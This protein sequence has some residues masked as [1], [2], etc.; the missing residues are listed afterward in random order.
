MRTLQR[1]SM[2]ACL[3]VLLAS[4]TLHAGSS[5]GC[6]ASGIGM[7]DRAQAEKVALELR[8]LG[9]EGLAAALQYYD[10]NPDPALQ[11]LIDTVAGQRDAVHSRLYWYTDLDQALAAAQKLNRPV[12]SL[13][14][15]GKL[16]DEYSCAN[17]R[18]FRTAL[19]ANRN[20][21]AFLRDNYVPHWSSERPVP[22]VT[23]DFRDGRTLKRTITGNSIHYVLS[24]S[25]QVVDALPG[26]Y[27][28]ALFL[29]TLQQA[30][31]VARIAD[32]SSAPKLASL[33]STDP[34]LRYHL[35]YQQRQEDALLRSYEALGKAAGVVNVPA[36]NK[37]NAADAAPRAMGKA[38]VEMPMLR[39]IN[40][41]FA[42]QLADHADHADEAT[43]NALAGRIVSSLDEG[44]I[45]LIRHQLC[46]A[47]SGKKSP[48]MDEQ[49][50][51][52]VVASFERVMAR[53]TAQNQFRFRR[54]ILSW[55]IEANQQQ[56]PLD[57]TV[58]NRR[59]YDELFLTPA[60]DPWLGLVPEDTYSALTADGRL[61]R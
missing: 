7:V 17:S 6:I 35:R 16:T 8:G 45:E 61:N 60:S 48:L 12:L 36:A 14:L 29:S 56:R 59:V 32:S 19:Y 23:I 41:E 52:R 34:V 50:L 33:G 58:L 21:S 55:L 27:A 38:V 10:K 43:W 30:Q 40:P 46:T 53:D 31:Y 25:G 51:K 54:Q 57:M 18:F 47:P 20:V 15:L 39:Q 49:Q 11:P 37:P 22:V 2:A 28:P 5:P 13:R 24:P 44:S 26:L 9:P 42:Q 1:I 4:A 3:A